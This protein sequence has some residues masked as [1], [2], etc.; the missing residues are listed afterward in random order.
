[1][2]YNYTPDSIQNYSLIFLHLK[3][4]LS[5]LFP[6]RQ[7]PYCYYFIFVLKIKKVKILRDNLKIG[8]DNHIHHLESSAYNTKETMFIP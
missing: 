5:Q 7:S 4:F 6:R 2:V 8:C 3:S 1:M